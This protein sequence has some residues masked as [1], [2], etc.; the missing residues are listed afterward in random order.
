MHYAIYC[1][2][3]KNLSPDE[4][5]VYLTFRKKQTVQLWSISLKRAMKTNA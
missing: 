1:Y 3:K 4:K 2:K 5:T